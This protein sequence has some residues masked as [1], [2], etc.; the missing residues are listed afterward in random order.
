MGDDK[1]IELIGRI[2]RALARIEASASR[3]APAPPP[4]A[5]DGQ[6]ALEDAHRTLRARVERAITQIDRLIAA[7]EAG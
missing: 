4:P 1:V 6:A 7:G 5:D 2:D 3:P